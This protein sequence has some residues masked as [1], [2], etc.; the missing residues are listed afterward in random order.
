M[1]PTCL[2][3]SPPT[4]LQESRL[5]QTLAFRAPLLA[6]WMLERLRITP[7]SVRRAVEEGFVHVYQ[8]PVITPLNVTG[9]V[10]RWSPGQPL[11]ED[12]QDISAQLRGRWAGRVPQVT[13]V[14]TC[15]PLAAQLLG[16]TAGRLPA[17]QHWDHDLL[18][19]EVFTWYVRHAP[20]EASRFIGEHQLPQAGHRVS[21]PDAFVSDSAGKIVKVVESGGRYGPAAVE[22]LLLYAARRSLLLE[23][24]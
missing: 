17:P 22:K 7:Q 11:P 24:W 5:I 16:S 14:Y 15:S 6:G 10:Y 2:P 4:D 13:P 21:D 3:D 18:T 9:P 23:I 1:S 20:Q 8:L 12:G 19:G